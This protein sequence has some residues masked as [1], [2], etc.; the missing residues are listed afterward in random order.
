M[1]HVTLPIPTRLTFSHE[2][3]HRAKVRNIL[4]GLSEGQFH[5]A[6]WALYRNMLARIRERQI[7]E[8][9]LTLIR[10]ID[11][12]LHNTETVNDER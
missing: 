3:Y 10:L 1:D 6:V 12:S 7:L 9:I 5:A 4:L 2:K 8:P 11:L